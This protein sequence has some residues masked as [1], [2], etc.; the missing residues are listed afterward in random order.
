M[1]K[2][3]NRTSLQNYVPA[4]NGDA[5]GEYADEETG[6]NIHFTNFKKP[7]EEFNEEE[8]NKNLIDGL[9]DEGDDD[10]SEE[11]KAK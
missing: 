6:S 5:S 7:D 11:M 2:K 10:F 4:G 8:F 9:V 3:P 1:P